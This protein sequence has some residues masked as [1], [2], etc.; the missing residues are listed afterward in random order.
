MPW[1]T[2]DFYIYD[3][4]RVW[5]SITKIKKIRDGVST[6]LYGAYTV[7]TVETVYT[8]FTVYIVWH[9]LH[10]WHNLHWWYCLNCWHCLHS[11]M[12]EIANMGYMVAE[13]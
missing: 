10:S 9:S 4:G 7:D 8:V 3:K 6:A 5:K 2:G 11:N 12:A 13:A 1:S